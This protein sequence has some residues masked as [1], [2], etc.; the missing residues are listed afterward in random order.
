MK[1]EFHL[2]DNETLE[3][4]HLLMDSI[5]NDLVS[6]PLTVSLRLAYIAVAKHLS[7]QSAGKEEADAISFYHL[8]YMRFMHILSHH[9]KGMVCLWFLSF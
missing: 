2:I 8:A 6:S 3:E 7:I 4:D 9:M 5:L 1:E